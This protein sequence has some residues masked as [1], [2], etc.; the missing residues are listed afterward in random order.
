MTKSCKGHLSEAIER[1]MAEQHG[2]VVTVN[3]WG[4]W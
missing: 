4:T 3:K 2:G 1:L